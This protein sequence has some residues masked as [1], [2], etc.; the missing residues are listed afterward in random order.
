MLG[1]S[2]RDLLYNFLIWTVVAFFTATQLFLKDWQDGDSISWWAYL[3]I[4]LFVWWIWGAITPFI[5]RLAEHFRVDKSSFW[6]GVAFHLPIAVLIVLLYLACY[7]MIWEFNATGTLKWIS[8]K[9]IFI[10]LFLNLFHWHFFIYMAIIGIVYARLYFVE[11]RASAL[12]GVNLEKELLQSQLN[13]LKMQLQPHFLF[14]ALNS[15]VSSIHQ[16]KA[17]IAA[18]MTTDLSELL[19]ISLAGSEK[20]VVSLRQEL[21][22]VKTY[23]NIEKHRFKDL[24]VNYAVPSGLLDVEVP[25]FFL[26]PLVE[27][28]IKHGI[29]KRA[30]ANLIVL[31]AEQVGGELYFRVYNEGP[32]VEYFEGGVGLANVRKRLE[33]MFGEAGQLDIG[34]ERK[35]V[36]V[37]VRIPV[38][39]EE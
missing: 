17:E 10:A 26:Q 19:R 13:Y 25:N 30:A 39:E 14:N 27:N 4:Q 34:A 15:I 22:H 23:L 7:A 35:G 32:S 37:T 31:E 24:K 18:N 21:H 16:D 20:Q 8:F 9:A 12:K 36:M 28:A 33:A 38:E 1:F 29:S 5:F 6:Q 11:S 3:K 2:R